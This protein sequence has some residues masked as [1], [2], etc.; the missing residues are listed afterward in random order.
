MTKPSRRLFWSVLLS[1]A[2]AGAQV[3]KL[4]DE[5]MRVLRPILERREAQ[6]QALRD[7]SIDDS[8]SPR[9]AYH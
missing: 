5:R 8:I 2:S 6:L 9:D 4:S 7:F 1:S 3:I